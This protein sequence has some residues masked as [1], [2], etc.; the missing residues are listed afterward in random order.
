MAYP[1]SAN[2]ILTA[3]DLNAAISTGVIST[4]LSAWTSYTP[5]WSGTLGNGTLTGKYFKAGR[6]VQAAIFLT[7]GSTTSHAAAAQTFSPPVT[8]ASSSQWVGGV[9][10]FDS[11][12]SAT[13]VRSVIM[14]T[15][16]QLALLSE[17]GAF[18]TNLVPMTWA[19]SDLCYLQFAYESAT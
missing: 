16:T 10:I 15:T 3:A 11:S 6:F 2:D 18:V 4:G 12:A 17:A 5:T 13:F 7:W 8:A 19:T 9:R 1:W 14:N